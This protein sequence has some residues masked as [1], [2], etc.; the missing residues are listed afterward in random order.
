MLSRTKNYIV[1][2]HAG[3]AVGAGYRCSIS[4]IPVHAPPVPGTTEGP[5]T[6]LSGP[7]CRAPFWTCM[8]QVNVSKKLNRHNI[9]ALKIIKRI[10]SDVY[11]RCFLSCLVNEKALYYFIHIENKAAFFQLVD[12]ITVPFKRNSLFSKMKLIIICNLC[13]IF[14]SLMH[15]D[16][17]FKKAKI[18][19][20]K[21]VAKNIFC[22][23]L[24]SKYCFLN[25]SQ[26]LH[27]DSKANQIF[28]CTLFLTIFWIWAWRSSTSLFSWPFSFSALIDIYQIKTKE[29]EETSKKSK[30]EKRKW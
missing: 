16:N 2:S 14:R 11:L 28:C 26:T 24:N 30:A 6:R 15:S 20:A 19:S 17:K 9:A 8:T 29:G 7:V 12:L 1:N 18:P 23:L 27:L 21:L 13:I 5:H 4:I 10:I 25:L 22:H 3:H